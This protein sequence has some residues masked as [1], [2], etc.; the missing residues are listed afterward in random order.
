MKSK[1]WTEKEINLLKKLYSQGL[2]NKEIVKHFPDRS[3]S[4]ITEKARH[5]KINKEVIKYWSKKEIELLK[6]LYPQ[7]ISLNEV[8]KHFPGREK[9]AVFAKAYK[10]NLKRKEV[11]IVND[12]IVKDWTNEEV[13][14]LKKL[15]PQDLSTDKIAE[16]FPDRGEQAIRNKAS[17]LGIKK[18]VKCYKNNKIVKDWTKEEIELLKEVYTQEFTMNEVL[19]HFPGRSK[20]A[21]VTKAYELKVKR[22]TYYTVNNVKVTDWT[23][24]DIK[25]LKKLYPTDIPMQKIMEKLPDKTYGSIVT[26]ASK[27]NLIKGFYV[28]EKRKL[29][30]RRWTKS[31]IAFLKK[32]V[33]LQY[34]YEEIKEGLENR[35]ISS[36]K[37]AIRTFRLSK[38]RRVVRGEPWT[39]YETRLLVDNYL[40]MT[41]DE[42]TEIITSRTYSAIRAKLTKL[43]LKKTRESKQKAKSG[44][45]W[46]DEEV[47]ILKANLDTPITEIF[48]L[49]PARSKD[50]IKVRRRILINAN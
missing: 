26:K 42:L 8:A 20:S 4:A 22:E 40:D 47:N 27:L 33:N 50:A 11:R 31:E 9:T 48:P 24:R 41:V 39:D 25:T 43:R 7:Q 21:I 15:Y 17:K 36:I 18:E 12:K 29:P 34:T 16:Y 1:K 38:E 13:E 6:K 19:K 49:L 28:P 45:M 32:G 14:L 37:N 5:L 2:S 23:S 44:R 10:L 46:T 35:T 3:F 30:S